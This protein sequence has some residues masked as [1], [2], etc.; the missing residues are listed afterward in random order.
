MVPRAF[1]LQATVVSIC[2]V[3]SSTARLA[4]EEVEIVTDINLGQAGSYPSHL[5]VSG[6]DLFFRANNI[7]GG[8][9]VELWRYDG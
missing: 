1:S 2:V 8:N 4:C 7:A 3:N 5:L 6:D 9:N